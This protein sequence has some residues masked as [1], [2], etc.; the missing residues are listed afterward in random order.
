MRIYHIPVSWTVYATMEVEAGDLAKA[1]EKADNLP[2][3]TDPD[4]VDGSFEVNNE[5]IEIINDDLTEEDKAVL[6][7][8]E[9]EKE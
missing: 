9:E 6:K 7:T 2:L 3:P 1:I 5:V 4:Y 8:R